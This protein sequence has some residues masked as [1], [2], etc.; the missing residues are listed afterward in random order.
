MILYALCFL[1]DS[2]IVISH[3]EAYHVPRFQSHREARQGDVVEE[4]TAY[5]AV[6][7]DSN[8]ESERRLN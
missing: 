5:S 1:I 7:E 3:E 2:K 6:S 8:R 4:R